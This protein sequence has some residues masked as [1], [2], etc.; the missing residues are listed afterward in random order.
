LEYSNQITNNCRPFKI[1]VPNQ[2]LN[3][4]RQRV[5]DYPWHEMPDDGG[6]EY[7][8]NLDYMKVLCAYWVEELDWR[9]QEAMLN[10]FTHYKAP[11]DGID[12]HFIYE[13]GSGPAPMPLLISHGWPGSVA[14][15]VK[16]I[17][18]LAHPER[19]GGSIEDA[20]DVV[21]P[22]LPGFGVSGRP[23]HPYG[24]RKIADVLSSL[25]TDTLGYDS[26]LARVA[27][28]VGRFRHGWGMIMRLLVGRSISTF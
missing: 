27:T 24:P 7:G 13:K 20:F 17:E 23:P 8:A 15:F 21:A 19:F 18:P 12:M 22:S 26:Y 16:I 3:Q 28:G 6:W 14:E 10:L 4:I 1:E 2:T 25:M 11:V 5:A 9:K